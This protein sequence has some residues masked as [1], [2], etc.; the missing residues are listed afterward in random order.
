MM[1]G[2]PRCLGQNAESLEHE[3]TWQCIVCSARAWKGTVQVGINQERVGF[4]GVRSIGNP[5]DDVRN[6]AIGF[7]QPFT[8]H[9][10]AWMEP[11]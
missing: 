8:H 1:W 5:Y 4:S 7:V 3:A 10:E 6:V 11:G 9:V 2:P